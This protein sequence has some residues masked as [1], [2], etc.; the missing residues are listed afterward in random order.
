[1]VPDLFG[2]VGT[3]EQE[4]RPVAGHVEDI[5]AFEQVELVAGDEV[6]VGYEVRRVDRFGPKRRCEAVMVPDFFES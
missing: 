6:G 2:P 1:M 4:G 5:D 3:V